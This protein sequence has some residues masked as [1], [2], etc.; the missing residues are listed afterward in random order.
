MLLLYRV[1][2]QESIIMRAAKVSSRGHFRFRFDSLHVVSVSF[3]VPCLVQ[4][5][6][7]GHRSA[8]SCLLL[9]IKA[10]CHTSLTV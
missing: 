6:S 9:Y 2:V 4:S 7:Y 3:R 10:K 1:F 5:L 8:R